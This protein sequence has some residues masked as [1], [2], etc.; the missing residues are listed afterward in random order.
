MAEL[1]SVAE[2]QRI[3]QKAIF[4]GAVTRDEVTRLA[5]SYIHLTKEQTR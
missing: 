5:A 4:H 2:A 3:R 1:M